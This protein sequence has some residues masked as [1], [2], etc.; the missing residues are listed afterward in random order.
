MLTPDRRIGAASLRM[1]RLRLRHRI[2]AEF[3]PDMSELLG[4]GEASVAHH[5]AQYV[6]PRLGEDQPRQALTGVEPHQTSV[7]QAFGHGGE[8]RLAGDPD[9]RAKS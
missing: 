6:D 4:I 3:L 7:Q 5:G 8:L 2:D 9:R 1:R